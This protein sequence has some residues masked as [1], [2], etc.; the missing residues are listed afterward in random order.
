VR[1]YGGQLLSAIERRDAAALAEMLVENQRSLQRAADQIFAWRVSQAES[2]INEL[3]QALALAQSRLQF[4]SSQEFMNVGEGL[5][6]ALLETVIGINAAIIVSYLAGAI[7]HSFPSGNAGVAGVAASPTATVKIGGPNAG[8]A[9]ATGAEA[10]KSLM[11]ALERGATVA[12]RMGGYERRR[13][14]WRQQAAEANIQ[15]QQVNAQ[16]EG[17]KLA[18][19]I[20]ALD[21]RNHQQLVDQLDQQ[22]EFL[23]DRFTSAD[24]YDWMVGMLAGTYFQSYRL[25]YAMA[26]RAERCYR[27]ELGL[28]DSSFIAFGYWDSLRRGLLAGEGLNHDLRRMQ[29][30]YLEQ[31]IRRYEITRFVSLVSVDPMAFITLIR[32]GTCDFELPEALFDADYPGHYQRRLTRVSVTVVYPGRKDTDNVK[33]TLTLLA[34]SVRLT[35]DVAAGYART[36]PSDARFFDHFGTIQRIVTGGAEDDPGLFLTSINNNLSDQR[37]LP[38]EGAGAASSWR[39][40]LPAQ[41]NEI[42]LSTV[43]DV[44]LHLHYTALDGGES[45]KQAVQEAVAAALPSEGVKAFSVQTGFTDAW[46]RFFSPAAGS[47]QELVLPLPATSFPSWTRGRTITITGL[48]ITTFSSAGGSFELE[49]QAPLSTTSVTLAPIPGAP[50]VA[51]G[52]VAVPSGTT[53]GTWTFRLRASGA[54]DW[55][56]L[57]NDQLG[58]V[59]IAAAFEVS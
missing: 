39:L 33:C 26:K 58:E 35:T 16:L 30:S 28:L 8:N 4:Y 11:T 57:T 9:A 5:E 3:N 55:R 24:L 42:D 23:R 36:G 17:A 32:T 19:E 15:I 46:E 38:F 49:P 18:R 21:E 25:A 40:E 47:D 48:T 53:P 43:G 10:L 44:V 45:F 22:I 12:A 2:R 37:Y 52:M 41:N 13:D 54:T 27:F 50:G 29:A 34:N 14:T 20:A 51:T 56:S 7:A 6:I 31:S 59:V 1:A